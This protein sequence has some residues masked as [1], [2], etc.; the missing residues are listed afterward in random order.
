MVSVHQR[1]TI[2]SFR[3]FSRALIA[4]LLFPLCPVVAQI[5]LETHGTAT[6]SS[7][8]NTAGTFAASKGIDGDADSFTHTKNWDGSWWQLELDQAFTVEH[9]EIVNRD[10]WDERLEAL[11]LRVYDGNN[12]LVHESVLTNPGA[13]GT[14]G[15]NLPDGT[16]VKRIWIGLDPGELNGQG[17][18]IVSV[19]EVIL[20]D[21][22]TVPNTDPLPAQV[23]T[24]PVSVAQYDDAIGVY[25]HGFD[26]MRESYPDL[27]LSYRLIQ[28]D[29][30][31]D[32][33][34]T[35]DLTEP[36]E[37]PG[38]ILRKNSSIEYTGIV[39][40]ASSGGANVFFRRF[41][42]LGGSLDVPTVVPTLAQNAA[43]EPGQ[44]LTQAPVIP[45]PDRSQLA[46]VAI[47]FAKRIYNLDTGMLQVISDINYPLVGSNQLCALSRQTDFPDD[48]SKRS[49]YVPLKS[50]FYDQNGQ[51]TV[52]RH[53]LCEVPL[54]AGWLAG[55]DD[56]AVNLSPGQIKVHQTDEQY[57][58]T[59]LLGRSST[60][61][62][63]ISGTMS[64][65]ADGN[66]YFCNA[67]PTQVVRFNI[68][69]SSFEKPPTDLSAL[70]D[71]YLPTDDDVLG[72]G[73]TA[74][75]GRWT[76]YRMV[77]SMNHS[78]PKRMVFGRTISLYD[79]GRDRYDWSGLFT[80][81]KDHWDDP[82][83][84]TNEF[85]LLVGSWPS[86][87]H[88]FYDTLPEEDGPL[89]RIQWFK[90]YGDTI[91]AQPYPN[92]VGGPWR[93]D[94]AS[95][96]TVIAFGTN[97]PDEFG[98][99]FDDAKSGPDDAK[100]FN[101][102]NRIQ[103]EDYGI[104][105]MDRSDLHFVLTGTT[106]NS[107]TG[108]IE[109]TY[110]AVSHMLQN[111][112]E[113]SEILDNIGGPSLSPAFLATPLPG[114]QRR[115]LA[116][117]ERG[118]YFA[119]YD[120]SDPESGEVAKTYLSLDSP[121][122]DLNLPLAA[123]IGTYGHQWVDLDGD[124]WLYISGYIGLT[125]IKYAENGTALG[126]YTMHQFDTEMTT[127]NLDA[128][129][130]GPIKRFRYLQ[131][132]LD[133]RMFLTGKNS[134][135][136]N[137]TAW[138]GGLF[139]FHRTQLDTFWR[140]SY[141]SRNYTTLRLRNRV[142]RDVDG[143]PLQEFYSTGGFSQDYTNTIPAALVPENT[144]PKVFK[145]DYKS[146][147]QMRDL[148]G[149]SQAGLDG[150]FELGDI[151]LS[152]DRRYLIVRQGN[153]LLT[154]DLQTNRFID[155]KT[156][157]YGSEPEVA[158]FARPSK[159]FSRAPDDRIFMH[160]RPS[161]AATSSMFIEVE[162]SPTGQL[163]LQP[164]LELQSASPAVIDDF[165]HL[166]H[167]YLPDLE[168]NDGSYDLF[169]GQKAVYS[170][171]GTVCQ[172]IEDYVPPRSHSIGRSLSVLSS[173]VIGA[174][175]TGTKPGVTPYRADCTD[176]ESISI[177]APASAG[178][179]FQEWRDEDGNVIGANSTLQLDM[180]EDRI[181]TA[182]YGSAPI[183]T[184]LVVS[185]LHYHPAAAGAEEILAGYSNRDQFE[186]IELMNSGDTDYNL[187][188]IRFVDGVTYDFSTSSIRTLGPGE[189]LLLVSNLGAFTERYGSGHATRIA[190][191]YSG[192]LSDDGALLKVMDGSAEIL[193]FTYDDQAPWPEGADG[194]G[195]SLVLLD[196][197]RQ[198][199]PDHND[200][201]N[202][203]GSRTV[204]GSPGLS[205][206][207]TFAEWATGFGIVDLS[208]G[209]D[210]D[211]DGRS[212]LLEYLQGT[213]PLVPDDVYGLT[214]TIETLEVEGITAPY[215][216]FRVLHQ[217]GV[218]D[219]DILFEQSTDIDEW[220]PMDAVYMD[221]ERDG[222]SRR[223]VAHLS[224]GDPCS[225]LQRVFRAFAGATEIESESRSDPGG[226]G[227]RQNFVVSAWVNALA[228]WVSIPLLSLLALCR[229]PLLRLIEARIPGRHLSER[230]FCAKPGVFHAVFRRRPDGRWQGSSLPQYR[231]SNR[232]VPARRPRETRSAASDLN[233]SPNRGCH[234][235]HG[236]E[237]SASRDRDRA[238][239]RDP[240]EA[241]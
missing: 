195:L 67:L 221:R 78:N 216:V 129:G 40:S 104:L 65:D 237:E 35:L 22:F 76:Y 132:G 238:S 16:Q 157:T 234:R 160:M 214:S 205:D 131:H 44:F 225:W 94:I 28:P 53:F 109:V 98:S 162:V 208:P 107:L 143:V 85:R 155:G 175:V 144:D 161:A 30:T 79:A 49:I 99:S 2:A 135:S 77:A 207:S 122:P 211:G 185:E 197:T 169:L 206:T 97:A 32:A 29:G 106:N 117:S 11:N 159:N 127:V 59:N 13:S 119:E 5:D 51:P 189:R 72:N 130:S 57:Q 7:D 31:I 168:N 241:A 186:F 223:G 75:N 124:D 149:F 74:K 68:A 230:L 152:R 148:M 153:Q 3:V 113:F 86:A 118:Y 50:H 21:E 103:F 71:Q 125:R 128:A 58:G 101:A 93:V 92:S 151:E 227:I 18:S 198:P 81:P 52:V 111:A 165:F 228:K 158:Y 100:P 200:P 178:L 114:Q 115:L 202:W 146:G 196:P 174:S 229:L 240:P 142:L 176:G 43:I 10:N 173:G 62:G 233:E 215:F 204:G 34:Q 203:R 42:P 187:S 48:D 188:G 182:V 172:L 105:T 154:F 70:A 15:E 156:L 24:D 139:S 201:A 116:V 120:V 219:V 150:D 235:R 12:Q 121:N 83:A 126:R 140:L 239:D 8:W 96:N 224:V 47:G 90:A 108:Q 136:R 27:Q 123:G 19:A 69:T 217:V 9:I 112:P 226:C 23:I 73:G 209:V 164:W 181:I 192:K 147:G 20:Y 1:R 37:K 66:I 95:D 191:Q 180:D 190:G 141:M 14:H 163:I 232:K 4:V 194:G 179:S 41:Y 33:V 82:V 6:Q 102:N 184:N 56:L 110:D 138:S 63:Q 26:L 231:C 171:G 210:S 145:W 39:L 133:G 55:T 167:T 91:Y 222:T 64:V 80:M 213:D 166:Q 46:E 38:I 60:G 218:E 54:D 25:L 88:S 84:F 199:P 87:A 137:G 89:R 36:W 17:D 212:D 220:T 134:P 193:S 61:L 170:G 177:T 236:S 45:L 183:V